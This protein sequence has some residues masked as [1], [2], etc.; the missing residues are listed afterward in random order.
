[1][2]EQHETHVKFKCPKIAENGTTYRVD[3]RLPQQAGESAHE[4]HGLAEA[5]RTEILCDGNVLELACVQRAG[6]ERSTVRRRGDESIGGLN[7]CKRKG[8][9]KQTNSRRL[10]GMKM[11]KQ[12]VNRSRPLYM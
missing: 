4:T 3:T 1:M 6:A 9:R 2:E 5:E 11:Y 8:N 12:R 10:K 7:G